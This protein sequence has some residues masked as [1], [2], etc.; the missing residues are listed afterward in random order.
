MNHKLGMVFLYS[1]STLKTY[2]NLVVEKQ[3]GGQFLKRI[4]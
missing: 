2:K 1:Q 3:V 4:I